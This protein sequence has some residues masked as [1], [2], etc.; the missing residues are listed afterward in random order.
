MMPIIKF[1]IKVEDFKSRSLKLAIRYTYSQGLV[2][3]KWEVL[4][5][6]RLYYYF[7]S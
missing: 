3:V 7:E 6:W 2:L 5:Y 4:I 1:N